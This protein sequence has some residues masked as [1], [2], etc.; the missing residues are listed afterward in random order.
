M[1]AMLLMTTLLAQVVPGGSG[2]GAPAPSG[3]DAARGSNAGPS[4]APGRVPG[5]SS[6]FAAALDAANGV[7]FRPGGRIGVPAGAVSVAPA[8]DFVAPL[9]A[10]KTLPAPQAIWTAT[11]LGPP[12][13]SDPDALPAEVGLEEWI[14]DGD[15]DAKKALDAL[16][17]ADKKPAVH[18]AYFAQ[19]T[20][21]WTK[22][23]SLFV[24]SSGNEAFRAQIEKVRTAIAGA[25]K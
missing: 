8:A 3:A 2:G 11:L 18:G 22:G 14:Y 20:A 13:S 9:F 19:P 24:L 4:C 16:A 12:A 25:K 6:A 7:D 17:G 23:S 1:L 5:P 10:D 21:W 15:A